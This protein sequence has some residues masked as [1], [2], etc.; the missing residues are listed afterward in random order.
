MVEVNRSF[1]DP[2]D[3]EKATGLKCT[4]IE[5]SDPEEGIEITIEGMD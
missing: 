1:F 2:A 3:V 5:P 4:S